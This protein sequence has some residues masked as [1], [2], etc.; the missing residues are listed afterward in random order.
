M[1]Q[2]YTPGLKVTNRMTLHV[3][4]LLPIKGEVLVNVGDKV[5]A[6]QIVA[7]TYMPG[8]ITPV[9][10]ANILSMPPGDV[11]ECVL[12]EEGDKIALDEPL[13]QTK[14]IFGM[15]KNVYKSKHEGRSRRSRRSPD[16]SSS[17]ASR[18]RCRCRRTSPAT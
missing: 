10:L 8:D 11:K 16:S 18:S 6:E 3:R 1:G 12:K 5:D 2:A 9:N 17:A 4:R 13:A 14:G 15:F 7:R